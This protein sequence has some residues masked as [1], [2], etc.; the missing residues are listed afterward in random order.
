MTGVG[1][2]IVLVGLAI[3]LVGAV[4]W[5]LGRLGFRGLPGDIRHESERVRIYIPVVTCLV[6]S[7]VLSLLVWLFRRVGG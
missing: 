6:I 7:A 4:V 2:T 5:F 1:R 3:A